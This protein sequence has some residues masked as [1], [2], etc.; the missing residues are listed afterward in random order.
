MLTSSAA[1]KIDDSLDD[2]LASLSDIN[3]QEKAEKLLLLLVRKILDEGSEDAEATEADDKA[4]TAATD[5][6]TVDAC[7]CSALPARASTS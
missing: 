2:S 1:D 4:G 7:T 3:C 6:T 5:L